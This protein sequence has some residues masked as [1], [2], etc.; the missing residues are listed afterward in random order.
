M[1]KIY[2]SARDKV[3][4]RIEQEGTEQFGWNHVLWWL[5][6]KIFLSSCKEFTR[7]YQF[8]FYINIR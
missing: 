2:N 4:P 8:M 5:A 6:A 1:A 7:I 3:N